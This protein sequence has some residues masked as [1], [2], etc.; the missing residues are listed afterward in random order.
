MD[1]KIWWYAINGEQKGPVDAA[2]FDMLVAASTIGPDTLVWREGMSDWAAAAVALPDEMFPS[3]WSRPASAPPPPPMRNREPAP[4][5]TAPSSGRTGAGGPWPSGAMDVDEH[6]TQFMDAVKACF[7][8]YA[9]FQG[10]ARRPELWYFALFNLIVNIVLG[11]V[12]MSIF[13]MD[14]G[15]S[16]L[17]NIYGLAVFVPA[18]AV[19]ARRLH[20]IGKSGWWQLIG[21]IPL[22]GWIILIIWFASRGDD[23]NNEYGPA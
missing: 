21:L 12:D 19:G 18:L 5:E 14:S 3:G 22:V 13:G 6:P 4:A 2:E 20:D 8:R 23:R 10:R 11:I 15:M 16:L 17:S 1:E 7:N 9:R